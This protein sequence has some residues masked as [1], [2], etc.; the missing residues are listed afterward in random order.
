VRKV[1]SATFKLGIAPIPSL[2]RCSGERQPPRLD[3]TEEVLV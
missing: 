2:H 1:K 3:T